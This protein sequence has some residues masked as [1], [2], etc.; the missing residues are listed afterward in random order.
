MLRLGLPAAADALAAAAAPKKAP[1]NKRKHK[2]T[3]SEPT[4]RSARQRGATAEFSGEEIDALDE[5]HK[6]HPNEGH[7]AVREPQLKA[8]RSEA[9]MLAETQ[10]WLERSRAALLK[11]PP[12]ASSGDK[13]AAEAERRWGQ[14]VRRAADG[15]SFD[16]RKYVQS[17][18]SSPPP[19]SP[20]GLLQEFYAFDTWQLLI[21]CV[22]MS[23]V[24]SWDTKHRCISAF[25]ERF[26]TPSD[27]L[28]ATSEQMLEVM[29]PLGLFE[30]R[31]RSVTAVTERFLA[32]PV[33]EV[34]L[35]P[36]VKIYGIGAF[37]FESFK[38]FC[39]AD[40]SFTPQDATLKIFSAW[41][42]RHAKK[43]EDR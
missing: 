34:G 35:E 17:R 4:R 7:A 29:K 30:N 42:K 38:L 26:P 28:H 13:W 5:D 37:G 2:T 18:M 19:P 43:E 27:A 36:N 25:F 32:A 14:E 6:N 40:L 10:R 12:A 9:D 22:L 24:S 3:P 41:Q 20:H 21:A 16:W 39:R 1:P 8:T 11:L 31:L 15:K 23:R 33:F